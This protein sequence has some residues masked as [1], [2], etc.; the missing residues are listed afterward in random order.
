MVELFRKSE[1]I[2][3]RRPIKMPISYYCNIRSHFHIWNIHQNAFLFLSKA[4]SYQG[5]ISYHLSQRKSPR[6]LYFAYAPFEDRY[7]FITRIILQDVIQCIGNEK[8][9][10]EILSLRYYSHLLYIFFL[11]FNV[12]LQTIILHFVFF[13]FRIFSL[14]KKSSILIFFFSF[15][16]DPSILVYNN[17]ARE[18]CTILVYGII[19]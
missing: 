17:I 11:L 9:W 2:Y 19:R 5:G 3:H 13:F 4:F 18:Y 1:T 16:I 12:S 8:K 6:T 10:I 15:Q 14:Q 7:Y